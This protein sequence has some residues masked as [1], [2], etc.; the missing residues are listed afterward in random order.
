MRMNRAKL[1]SIVFLTLIW[2]VPMIGNTQKFDQKYLKWKAEQEL[3]DSQLHI[4]PSHY[5]S[6]PDLATSTKNNKQATL[7]RTS[8][9]PATVNNSAATISMIKLNSASLV[10]LRELSGVGEK[11]AAAIVDYRQKNGGFKT[12]DE[13]RNVKGIGPKLLEKNKARLAL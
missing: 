2:A 5:L 11:K 12:V 10:E 4:Q 1:L 8:Q 13:L 9:T 7:T 3:K 6:K